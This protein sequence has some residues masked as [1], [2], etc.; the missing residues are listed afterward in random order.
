MSE[1]LYGWGPFPRRHA[2]V[3]LAQL[4]NNSQWE[5]GTRPIPFLSAFGLGFRLGAAISWPHFMAFRIQWHFMAFH[6]IEWP[7]F[8]PARVE[9]QANPDGNGEKVIESGYNEG[10]NEYK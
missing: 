10:G 5:A 6:G 2:L 7:F 9:I 8:G 1:R 4:T 3:S